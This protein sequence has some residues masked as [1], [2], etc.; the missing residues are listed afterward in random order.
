MGKYK[1]LGVNIVTFLWATWG[2]GLFSLFSFLCIRTGL[3]RTSM[4]LLT[5]WLLQFRY[6]VHL[7]R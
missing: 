4:A 7:C 5:Q 6:V 3:P 1:K 2:V